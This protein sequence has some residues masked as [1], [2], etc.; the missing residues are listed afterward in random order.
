M[1]PFYALILLTLLLVACN[2]YSG[3]LRKIKK[4]QEEYINDQDIIKE[5]VLDYFAKARQLV[6]YDSLIK[7]NDFREDTVFLIES[8]SPDDMITYGGIWGGYNGEIINYKVSPE[9]ELKYTQ[10]NYYNELINLF[11]EMRFDSI[12]MI[13]ESPV[14]GGRVYLGTIIVAEND[15]IHYSFSEPSIEWQNKIKKFK[16]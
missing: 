11:E 13:S 15:Y 14:Y 2:K 16:K 5:K 9:G 4:S 10:K 7:Y 3:D 12:E 1:K 8:F 6:F